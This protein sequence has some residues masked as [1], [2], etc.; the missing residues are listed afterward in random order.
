[1]GFH[2]LPVDNIEISYHECE[3]LEF[4]TFTGSSEGCGFVLSACRKMIQCYAVGKRFLLFFVLKF[5]EHILSSTIKIMTT[6]IAT[7]IPPAE[8]S[9]NCINTPEFAVV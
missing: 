3:T 7:T 6:M 1:M 5:S 2:R 9:I 8:P 4:Y